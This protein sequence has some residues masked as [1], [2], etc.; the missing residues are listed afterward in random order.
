MAP[1]DRTAAAAALALAIAMVGGLW[2]L[3]TYFDTN[4]TSASKLDT[5]HMMMEINALELETDLNPAQQKRLEQL[6]SKLKE[7]VGI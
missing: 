2:T 4:Y 1:I 5:V 3:L 6:K 7:K